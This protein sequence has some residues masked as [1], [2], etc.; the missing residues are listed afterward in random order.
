MDLAPCLCGH[1]I[2]PHLEHE[3]CQRLR[4]ALALFWL[5]E[6]GSVSVHSLGYHSL[7]EG[8][9]EELLGDSHPS[10][11]HDSSHHFV[12]LHA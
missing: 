7:S 10:D 9:K 6:S 8:L 2:H 11:V 12:H 1:C 5:V 3:R 4:Q